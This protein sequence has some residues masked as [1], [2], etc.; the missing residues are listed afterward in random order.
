MGYDSDKCSPRPSRPTCTAVRL[1]AAGLQGFKFLSGSS[2]LRLSVASSTPLSSSVLRPRGLGLE[3]LDPYRPSCTPSPPGANVAPSSRGG[4]SSAGYFAAVLEGLHGPLIV[5][6]SF[7]PS[8]HV[9]SPLA[10]V[11]F[12]FL[13]AFLA[14]GGSHTSHLA[15]LS[16]L[17]PGRLSCT[18]ACT[19]AQTCTAN[20]MFSAYS[21]PR[22]EH[23]C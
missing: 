13:S 12:F 4:S 19:R 10:R 5:C 11:C 14:A 2:G 22:G 7:R 20:F 3:M 1:L 17:V 8:E 18:R 9:M 15:V 6:L 21:F 23:Y 16:C